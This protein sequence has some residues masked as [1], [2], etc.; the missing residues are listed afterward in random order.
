VKSEGIEIAI[1]KYLHPLCVYLGINH[2]AIPTAIQEPVICTTF[3]R[4]A[5]FP[6][7]FTGRNSISIGKINVGIPPVPT[8]TI[9]LSAQKAQNDIAK[10]DASVK[11]PTVP[12]HKENGH[13]CPAI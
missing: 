13:M 3:T 10:G 11:T 2:Q 4:E 5:I 1:I 7:F 6:L 9:S 12:I 8:D